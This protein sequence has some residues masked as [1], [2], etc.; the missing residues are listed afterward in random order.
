MRNLLL[1]CV[2][3]CIS[4]YA[5]AASTHTDTVFTKRHDVR[6]FINRMVSAHHFNRKQL[7]QL[8]A[9]IKVKPQ[10]LRALNKPAE[11]TTWRTYQTLFIN[12]Q[13]IENGLQFWDKHAAILKKAEQQYG[14]PASIIVATLGVETKYGENMGRYRVI[15]SLSSLAFSKSSRA[16]FFRNELEQFLLLTREE[17]LNPLTVMG[18]Y[19]GAM[20]QPQFMPSSYRRYAIHFSKSRRIDL[21]HNTT[22][23]I[24]SIANYYHRCGWKLNEPV[25]LPSRSATLVTSKTALK[26][27]LIALPID[28]NHT[29]EYWVGF[30]NFDVIKRYNASNLYAMAV[31]QLSHSI[32]ALRE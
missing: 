10:V 31:F 29:M 25:A 7:T 11:K 13:R 1:S 3:F 9:Q 27:K 14:V 26:T 20:G 16:H 2:L 5:H 12:T 22:N 30:H 15:D 32:E 19:A 4:V 17:K 23:V 8:F 24:G 28:H 6:I 21:M 18:S